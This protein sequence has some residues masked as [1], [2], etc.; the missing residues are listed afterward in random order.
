MVERTNVK[1]MQ[2]ISLHKQQQLQDSLWCHF[3]PSIFYYLFF[4]SVKLKMA[5]WISLYKWQQ[6]QQNKNNAYDKQ[7]LVWCELAA[8]AQW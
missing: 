2:V 6:Q 1:T 5:V 4:Y 7:V 8:T 3:I